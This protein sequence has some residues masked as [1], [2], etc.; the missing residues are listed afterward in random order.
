MRRPAALPAAAFALGTAA[1]AALAA[2]PATA[3]AAAALQG[4]LW[5]AVVAALVTG[6]ARSG[7]DR[8]VWGLFAAG[9]AVLVLGRLALYASAGG[10]L[11]EPAVLERNAPL[12]LATLLG[13]PLF[14]AGQVALLRRRLHRVRSP[15]LD[16][17]LAVLLLAA[18]CLAL[19]LEPLHRATGMGPATIAAAVARP[20]LDVL[21][22]VY[23]LT[24]C[25]LLGRRT[26]ARLPL[27]AAAFT[28]LAA[29]DVTDLLR[30]AGAAGPVV[31][32]TPVSVAVDVARLC[33][34]A[35]LVLAARQPA[36]RLPRLHAEGWPL[37]MAPVG[38]LLGSLALLVADQWRPLPAAAVVLTFSA[39]GGVT[40]KVLLAFA[41]LTR[42]LGSDRQAVTD[43]LTGL[44]NRRA[45]FQRLARPGGRATGL[46]LL[47][48][49]RFKEVNDT[50]GHHRGDDLLRAVAARLTA[51]LPHEALL[52]RLGGD[53]FALVLP[54]AGTGAS[55]RVADDLLTALTEPFTVGGLA[56][57][58]GASIGVATAGAVPP[59]DGAEPG[60]DAELLRQA[61]A[62]MYVAKRAGGGV[63]VY[64]E[65]AD[66][67]ARERLQLL[68]E[69]RTGIAAGQ[70][71][72]RYQPQVDVRTG[73][74]VGVEALVRWQHPRR[75]LLLP[76]AFL[77]LAEERGLTGAITEVVLRRAVADAVRWHDA[78]RPLRVAVNVAAGDLLDPALPDLVRGTA[79]A[80]GLDP[81][82]LVVE[83]TETT[84]M[85]DPERSRR[86]IAELLAVGAGISID[87]YGTGYSSLAYL[88]DLPAAELKLD[89]VFTARVAH[90]P[91]TAAIVA[92]TA[93][94]AHSLG[95]RL[96]AEGVEDEETLHLLRSLGVDETQGWLH[97]RPVPAAELVT[98]LDRL[99][100]R[101][102]PA[103]ARLP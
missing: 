39:V 50:L 17:S 8:A 69:L 42:L 6:A 103:T 53:E 85:R 1:S 54:G 43:D 68:E 33:A 32:G 86:T 26:D 91:R 87:D 82:A 61:D 70:L 34:G 95:M 80:A 29:A 55:R 51:R 98:L 46:L 99:D 3:A 23:A 47:D 62:A 30:L 48:L 57:H 37:L 75:G 35:L 9:T 84:L 93:D 88:R 25:S 102:T 14:Y 96:L 59:A 24:T 15:W 77:G 45:L 16:G 7:A 65:A 63:A 49:D 31:V 36:P 71:V 40:V 13:Y 38:V 10:P 92:G 52:T 19:F 79:S 90:D 20:S 101:G 66:R 18:A 81:G 28:V 60:G 74:V 11:V 22:A 78:G 12:V 76:G 4:L 56:V 73:A 44:A 41:E 83:I 72:T 27:V 5:L 94:L 58:V 21:M 100:P 89:R 67:S 2:N 97:G 64:D